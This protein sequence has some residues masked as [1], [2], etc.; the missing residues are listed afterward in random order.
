MPAGDLEIRLQIRH[1]RPAALERVKNLP[2]VL[3]F[4]LPAALKVD[5]HV[6]KAAAFGFNAPGAAEPRPSPV[7]PLEV[8]GRSVVFLTAP[9]A[10]DWAEAGDTLCGTIHYVKG[11]SRAPRRPGGWPLMVIPRPKVIPDKPSSGPAPVRGGP[12]EASAEALEEALR[13][14]KVAHLK[15]LSKAAMPATA[16]AAAPAAAAAPAVEDSAARYEAFFNELTADVAR[17]PASG[18]LDLSIYSTHLDNAVGRA[19]ATTAQGDDAA[20]KTAT[21]RV[22]VDAADLLARQVDQTALAAALGIAVDGDDAEAKGARELDDE[23]K[24][25]RAPRMGARG[26]RAARAARLD[27]LVLTGRALRTDRPSLPRRSS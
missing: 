17:A 11:P 27:R 26:W 2:L 9:A 24:K 13:K 25:V 18:T 7:F 21:L 6:S 10:P 14:A 23:R 3:E 5:A 20:Q 19:K 12:A 4:R 1:D 22:V 16:K 15:A 8:G